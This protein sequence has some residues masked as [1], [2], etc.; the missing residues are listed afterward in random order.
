MSGL[1]TGLEKEV[2]ALGNTLQG[3]TEKIEGGLS[4]ELDVSASLS[5][6]SR[7]AGLG[8]SAAE[9]AY[10]VS[11]ALPEWDMPRSM[12]RSRHWATR[13]VPSAPSSRS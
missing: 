1:Q 4:P 7:T 6:S 2:P 10:A 5:A 13:S 12:R 8:P 3:I 11:A 9:L